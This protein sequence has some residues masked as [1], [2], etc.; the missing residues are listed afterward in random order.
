MRSRRMRW[1]QRR[2]G[3]MQLAGWQLEEMK[4]LAPQIP[5]EARFLF[6]LDYWLK[7]FSSVFWGRLHRIGFSH[8]FEQAG[9]FFIFLQYLLDLAA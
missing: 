4:T 7:D 5:P 1:R 3:T 6:N 9:F 2:T 8:A